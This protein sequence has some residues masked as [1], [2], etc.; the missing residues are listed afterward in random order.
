MNKFKYLGVTISEEG[1]SEEAVKARVNAAWGKWRDIY[2]V[3]S[4]KNMSR[5]LK[6]KLSLDQ[7]FCREQNA[8]QLERRRNRFS[9]KQK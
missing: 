2:G 4:D 8:G 3:I 7:Y 1:G 9:R 5:K 6:I